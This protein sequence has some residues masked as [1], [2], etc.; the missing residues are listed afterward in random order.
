M[1]TDKKQCCLMRSSTKPI[2]WDFSICR[3]ISNGRSAVVNVEC[4]GW[5]PRVLIH[6]GLQQ[7]TT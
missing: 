6:E 5:P 7:T 2:H 4:K 3:S 1:L